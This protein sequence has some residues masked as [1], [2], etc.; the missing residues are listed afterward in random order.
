MSKYKL[1]SR[2]DLQ[3]LP[4]PPMTKD[5]ALKMALEAIEVYSPD[6]MHG[7]SKKSYVKAIKLALLIN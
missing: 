7:L 6:Y 3:N 5:I 2:E 4:V 1:L